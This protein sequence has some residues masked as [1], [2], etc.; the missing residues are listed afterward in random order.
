M[1][2]NKTGGNKG[3]KVARKDNVQRKTRLMVEEGEYYGVVTKMLGNNQ[4]H[5]FCLDGHT[6]LCIIRKKFTGKHKSQHFL[7]PGTWVLVGLRDWETTHKDKMDK[8]DLLE[9]YNDSDKHII[10]QQSN[11][12]V[13]CLE[14]KKL[15]GE[16]EVQPQEDDIVFKEEEEEYIIIDDI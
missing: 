10:S 4:C 6:R 12:N 14:E 1:V 11:V 13:K 8:C 15:E 7:K 3:K 5:V 9:C 2:L 16:E